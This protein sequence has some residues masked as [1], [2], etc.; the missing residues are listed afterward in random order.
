MSCHYLIG[1]TVDESPFGQQV[2]QQ[3]GQVP[4][5]RR[6]V[7]HFRHPTRHVHHGLVGEAHIQG[8]VA[9]F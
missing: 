6:D 1:S 9:S 4:G 2:T 7:Q 3:G 5:Q 8:P